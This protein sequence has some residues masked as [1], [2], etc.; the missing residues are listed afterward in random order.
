MVGCVESEHPLEW[1]PLE[2][3]DIEVEPEWLPKFYILG[4]LWT[5]FLEY[6]DFYLQLFNCAVRLTQKLAKASQ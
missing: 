1:Y 2:C 3:K 4:P 5:D 6:P